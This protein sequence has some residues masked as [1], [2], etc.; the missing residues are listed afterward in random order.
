MQLKYSPIHNTSVLVI[1][2]NKGQ[3]AFVAKV[4]GQLKETDL[5][6]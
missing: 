3:D 1:S 4:F 6:T 2:G 5:L